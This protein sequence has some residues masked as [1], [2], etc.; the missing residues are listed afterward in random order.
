MAP[1]YDYA[2]AR[3]FSTEADPLAAMRA[4]YSR[5]QAM[6]RPKP[7]LVTLPEWRKIL[8]AEAPAEGLPETVVPFAR[9]DPPIPPM[10]NHRGR[11]C[12]HHI[13]GTMARDFG[14]TVAEITGPRRGGKVLK[15]RHAVIVA[16]YQARPDLTLP[17]LGRMFNRD[18]TTI[19]S[20][21][22][23]AGVYEART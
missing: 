4:H 2:H 1:I 21:L 20:A 18:H 16:V 14:V 8:V 19:L 12:P 15:A 23:K 17:A 22:R 3:D 10:F 7:Q 13:I 11:I 5:V 9:K 6:N